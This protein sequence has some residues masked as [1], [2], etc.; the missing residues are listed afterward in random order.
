MLLVKNSKIVCFTATLQKL[1]YLL[2]ELTS[3]QDCI[4]SDLDFPPLPKI[5]QILYVCHFI[6][7]LSIL[8]TGNSFQCWLRCIGFLTPKVLTWCVT[9]SERLKWKE[10]L[11]NLAAVLLC[12]RRKE[13]TKCAFAR[14]GLAASEISVVMPTR[15]FTQRSASFSINTCKCSAVQIPDF[16]HLTP[17][18]IQQ[19]TFIVSGIFQ[20]FSR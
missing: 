10:F 19:S 9:A 11:P 7:F 17:P 18:E 14:L 12:Q 8:P 2:F 3:L 16:S 20:I 5:H 15:P 6:L 13:S 1:V 4:Q